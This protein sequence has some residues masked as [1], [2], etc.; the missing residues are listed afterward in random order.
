MQNIHHL[1]LGL[2]SQGFSTVNSTVSS[3]QNTNATK[4]RYST[5]RPISN[6][7]IH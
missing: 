4:Y 1:P 6:C 2:E 3:I 7:I 5:E